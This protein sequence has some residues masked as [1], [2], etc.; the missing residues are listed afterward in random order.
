MYNYAGPSGDPIWTGTG[1]NSYVSNRNGCL[2]TR[3][4]S[5]YR[6][7]LG[8]VYPSAYDGW[9]GCNYSDGHFWHT[10][11][12][13]VLPPNGPFCVNR[14][15]MEQVIATPSSNHPGGVQLALADG[16]VRFISE[17]IDTGTAKAT[18]KD[19]A[20]QYSVWGGLGSRD[21]GETISL[22]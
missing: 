14:S 20:S 6:T 16:A 1:E 3:N 21:G 22:P 2:D 4:G 15:S 13:T 7:N 18:P 12:H 19:G 9:G 10:V 5:D 8:I 17:K 11:F